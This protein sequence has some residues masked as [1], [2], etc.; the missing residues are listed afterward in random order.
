MSNSNG[1]KNGDTVF[2][3]IAIGW[4][5]LRMITFDVM[6]E[7]RL[8]AP[9]KSSGCPDVN[10]P[11][12]QVFRLKLLMTD[13]AMSNT[14]TTKRTRCYRFDPFRTCSR[15]EIQKCPIA[16]ATK[17]VSPFLWPLLLAGQLSE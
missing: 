16:M 1:H 11:D 10:S 7:V 13:D 15:N 3:A 8:P 6:N 14:I 17:T 5:T 12:G 2:V 9:T 4:S